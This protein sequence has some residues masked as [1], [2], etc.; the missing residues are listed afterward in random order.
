[1]P[2]NNSYSPISAFFSQ[3]VEVEVPESGLVFRMYY[4]P[5]KASDGTVLVFHHG[6][7]N[8]ALSFAMLAKEV[9]QKSEGEL[10][11]IA[12]DARRHGKPSN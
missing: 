6:A 11:V 10:G 1:M 3:A 5:P 7:G 9:V 2:S 12:L 4:T 8:S